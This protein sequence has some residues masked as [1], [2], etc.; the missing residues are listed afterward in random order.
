[1]FV[2]CSIGISIYKKSSG[3]C[4][5]FIKYADTAM[6]RAKEN[7][8]T[9]YQFYSSDMTEMAFER[10]FMETSMR[11][12]LDKDEFLVY[13][14]PQVDSQSNKIIGMEA[15]VRWNHT[16]M[17]LI[18]PAAFIPLAEET[19]LILALDQWVMKTGMNQMRE[20]YKM[21]YKPGRLSLNLSVKQL[22][23]KDFISVV[24]NMLNETGCK[25]EWIEFE[26]TESHIMHNVLEAIDTLNRIK[27]LGISI[28]IDDFG[29]GYSSLSYLKKL[30]VDKL[31]IDR[32]F[33]ID[34]PDNKEDAAITNA[35]IAVAES[36]SLM[37]VAE[38]V[39]TERQKSYLQ[40]CGCQN[41]QGFFYYK[42]MPVEK[43]EDVLKSV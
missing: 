24:K 35:I 19:G 38:G 26:I 9:N 12:A 40:E 25:A 27:E 29:T 20:W 2:S 1:M 17:G 32:S 34:I 13:Y 11:F 22:Q 7:G 30:P 28:A 14:Q 8:R 23:H 15:L 41:I 31:K 4:Q 21:G 18:S 16:T 10:V 33:I 6:Y 42:P 5:D 3:D 37:V 43:M 36:L 39:E